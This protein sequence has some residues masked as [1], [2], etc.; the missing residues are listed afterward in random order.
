MWHTH[1]RLTKVGQLLANT[2]ATSLFFRLLI[3]DLS[4]CYLYWLVATIETRKH[5]SR[6]HTDRDPPDRDPLDRDTTDRDP[7]GQ[8][9]PWTDTPLEGTLDQRQRPQER[10]WDQVVR[11]EVT[12]HSDPPRPHVQND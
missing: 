12:S 1:L 3:L 6:M 2:K 8:G 5:S 9:T 11:Q 4:I 7:L 10:T